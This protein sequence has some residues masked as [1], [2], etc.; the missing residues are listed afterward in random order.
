MALVPARPRKSAAAGK[1]QPGPRQS[2]FLCTQ[3][4][5]PEVFDVLRHDC[6]GPLRCPDEHL[7]ITHCAQLCGLSYSHH[8]VAARSKSLG[9]GRRVHLVEQQCNVIA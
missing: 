1:Q 6:Q 8:V 2:G 3:H 5:P 9:D 7:V 4:Q